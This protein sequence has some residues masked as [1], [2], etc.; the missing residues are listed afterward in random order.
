MFLNL[1]RDA[2]T[3][4]RW[5]D[6]VSIFCC[7]PPWPVLR[8]KGCRLRGLCNWP[9]Q[10]PTHISIPHPVVSVKHQALDTC[11]APPTSDCTLSLIPLAVSW[12]QWGSVDR[13]SLSNAS[14][15]S[16]P[17]Q[18]VWTETLYSFHQYSFPFS[19]VEQW[20]HISI[21][22][23]AIGYLPTIS[24]THEY[25]SSITQYKHT[26]LL[27]NH[28]HSKHFVHS[29]ICSNTIYTLSIPFHAFYANLQIDQLGTSRNYT[30]H[31][32]MLYSI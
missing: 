5:S 6:S 17:T 7:S 26:L 25:Y 24:I 31:L 20:I 18:W 16:N 22:F 19:G 8:E 9:P 3:Y 13:K 12:I 23:N 2:C 15:L 4:Q 21:P 10:L 28:P 30:E 32:G 29:T 27:T 14:S 1:T 11:I